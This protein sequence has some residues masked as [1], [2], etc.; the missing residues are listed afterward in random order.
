[1]TAHRR[2][3]SAAIWLLATLAFAAPVAAFEQSPTRLTVVLPAGDHTVVSWHVKVNANAATLRLYR[4]VDA[5]GFELVSEERVATGAHLLSFVDYA[6]HGR[7][8]VFR[9]TYDLGDGVQV[10]LAEARCIDP[11]LRSGS[12]PSAPSVRPE[13]GLVV[14]AVAD[15]PVGHGTNHAVMTPAGR[16]LKAPPPT[17]PPEPARA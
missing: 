17:P 8:V 7:S 6:T 11:L 2:G 16:D 14:A 3:G 1:M 15:I 10:D 13:R 4:A 5:A 9:A 12:L